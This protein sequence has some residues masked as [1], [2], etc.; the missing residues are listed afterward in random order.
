MDLIGHIRMGELASTTAPGFST[1]GRLTFLEP[2]LR[3]ERPRRSNIP[4]Y[5]EVPMSPPLWTA[6][7][8]VTRLSN[9]ACEASG[10]PG[11]TKWSQRQACTVPGWCER[12]PSDPQTQ[13]EHNNPDSGTEDAPNVESAL[14][15]AQ[16]RTPT[17]DVTGR[18]TATVQH[19][20]EQGMTSQA[21]SY[22]DNVCETAAFSV[23]VVGYF[24]CCHTNQL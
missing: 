10:T 20:R 4:G 24:S 12:P 13:A 3:K 1:V 5:S 14:T 6:P 11:L 17:R 2:S 7:R 21:A 22:R 23:Y 9:Q 15:M 19:P 8:T 18:A 16:M